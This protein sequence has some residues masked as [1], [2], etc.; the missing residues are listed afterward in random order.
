MFYLANIY[1]NG[2]DVIKNK[3]KAIQLLKKGLIFDSRSVKIID[4]LGFIFYKG[5]FR[6]DQLDTI[7][8]NEYCN[9]KKAKFYFEKN[10]RIYKRNKKKF[11]QYG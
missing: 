1:I 5:C 9:L 11:L 2:H 10:Y 4:A 6:I 8:D 7:Y 3:K